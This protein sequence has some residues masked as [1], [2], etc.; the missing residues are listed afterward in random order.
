MGA[1]IETGFFNTQ[2]FSPG[3]VKKS[4]C[5]L[6]E[7]LVLVIFREESS[8]IGRLCSLEF[9]T[10]G[11]LAPFRLKIELGQLAIRC[12]FES[13]LGQLAIRCNFEPA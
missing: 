3:D 5:C 8:G 1:E 6:S 13:K 2:P 9:S 4:P 10:H 12:N 7:I 11:P